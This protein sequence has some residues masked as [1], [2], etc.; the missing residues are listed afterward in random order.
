[1]RDNKEVYERQM[2]DFKKA[3]MDEM[4]KEREAMN[5]HRMEDMRQQMQEVLDR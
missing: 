2:E 1:M 4:A 3:F 5:A